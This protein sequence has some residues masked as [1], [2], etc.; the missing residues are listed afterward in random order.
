MCLSHFICT[1][2]DNCNLPNLFTRV[3]R[4]NKAHLCHASLYDCVIDIDGASVAPFMLFMAFGGML[5]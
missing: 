1:G 5:A 3:S 4:S 2:A